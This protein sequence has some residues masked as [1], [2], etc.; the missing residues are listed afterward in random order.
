MLLKYKLS[1]RISCNLVN[2]H[3]KYEVEHR[4]A[5]RDDILL[6]H[7]EIEYGNTTEKRLGGVKD[8]STML[9]WKLEYGSNIAKK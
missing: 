9:F 4:Y 2:K 6:L 8:D 3:I 1:I 7:W 5:T